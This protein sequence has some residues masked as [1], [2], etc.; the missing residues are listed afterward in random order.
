MNLDAR[1]ISLKTWA[2]DNKNYFRLLVLVNE[3]VV[4]FFL[5]EAMYNSLLTCEFGDVVSLDLTV[6]SDGKVALKNVIL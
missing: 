2:K 1:F 5:T 3:D 6:R 4:T